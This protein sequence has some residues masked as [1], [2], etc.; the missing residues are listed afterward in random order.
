MHTF[1]RKPATTP[2]SLIAIGS[3]TGG[4]EALTAVLT[5]LKPP[6][7]PIVIVQH[8]PPVFSQMLADRLNSECEIIVK[9]G[10]SGESLLQNHAYIAPGGKHMTINVAGGIMQLDCAAG[11][12]VH[13]VCPS[14]DVLFNSIAKNVKRHVLGI[15]L[16]GMGRDGA[17]G[18]LHLKEQ[19]AHTI[20]QNKET[21]AVYGMPKAAY[22][23]G[24]VMK[25][26][27][28]SS[29]APAIMNTVKKY[30]L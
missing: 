14:V 28:L 7:P 15:I 24:A 11:P 17:A 26:L 21:C 23:L 25:Q 9:E 8:I 4:T 10:S 20:G 13:S 6:L 18:L 27:P 19:G 3:S 29:I 2:I 12:P 30:S 1:Y 16:T 5:R 22:E